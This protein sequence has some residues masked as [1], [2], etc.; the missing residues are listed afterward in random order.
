MAPS[1]RLHPAFELIFDHR[2]REVIRACNLEHDIELPEGFYPRAVT[3]EVQAARQEPVTATYP[4]Q[5]QDE[6]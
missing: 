4:W 5:V 6:G 2:F 3:V 1:N